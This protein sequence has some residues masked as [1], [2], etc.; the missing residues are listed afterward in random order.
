MNYQWR[1]IRLGLSDELN[2]DGVVLENAIVDVRWK[3]I[4]TG[5]DGSASFIGSTKLSAKD[6]SA[7][8]FI[9]LDNIKEAD[10]LS[11]VQNSLSESE[12]NRINKI[13]D[14]KIELQKIRIRKPSW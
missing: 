14:R 3:R 8:D 11:W 1:I 9:S 4:A 5:G 2:N 7:S 13:L 6:V 10:V 12:I